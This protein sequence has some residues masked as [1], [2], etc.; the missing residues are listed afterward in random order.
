M[1]RRDRRRAQATS[2][3]MPQDVLHPEAGRHYHDAVQHLKQGRFAESETAHR[4][5][6]SLVPHHAPSL[7]HLGLIAFK[8]QELESAVDFIRKSVAAQPDYY[9]AWLNLA[10]I[11]GELRRSQEAIDACRESVALQPKNAQGH[12][13]LGNL[14]RIA[15]NDAEAMT[16][17]ASALDLKP[18]QPLVL[19]RLGELLLKSGD[20]EAATTHCDRALALD[21]ELEEARNLGRRLAAASR[22]VTTLAAE[23]EAQSRTGAERAKKLDGLATFLR[24]E[25]RF[26]EA[27]EL[28]ARAIAADPSVADYHFNLALS[29]EG[30]GYGKD[31]LASYQEGLKLDPDRAEAYAAVGALLRG[32]NMHTGAIQALEHAVKLNPNLA[33]AHYNLA[34]TH[35]LKD[36]YAAA[37]ESFSK[38]V[39]CAPDSIVNRFEYVNL[40]RLICDWSGVDEEERACLEIFRKN[41]AAQIAPFQLISLWATPADQLQAAQGYVK[42]FDVPSSL[43]FAPHK[44]HIGAGPR[45]RI[46]FLS[47]D[48]FEH[49]TAMLFTEVLESVARHRLLSAFEHVRKIGSMRNREAAELIHSD[50][51]DVLVDL[52]GYTRDARSEIFAYRP[53]PIQV[54]YLGYPGTM[55]AD[56]IDYIIADAIVAPMT[57]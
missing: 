56:F 13:V 7:H 12:T 20:V 15:Q 38:G 54:N 8:R 16:A 45:I 43:K 57:A 34:V 23:I 27:A 22:S 50:A 10:I 37:L 1:N 49:A 46:G 41:K 26:A 25:R 11:L 9:D 2:R 55:G 18:D 40:R 17:Y 24:D 21:P 32:M 51:I 42:T 35:K 33:S 28:C 31:A 6:L 14:L 4:R 5:V 3:H 53:A 52:K 48:F 29:L 44:N 36:N 19:A 47:C 30:M 39:A